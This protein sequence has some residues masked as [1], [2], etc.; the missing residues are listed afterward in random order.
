[1]TKKLVAIP[2]GNL[3]RIAAMK[4][5]ATLSDLKEKT[6]VDRKT[7]RTINTGGQV[8]ETT[9]QAIA[10]K[11]RIPLAHFLGPSTLDEV[12][13]AA[14]P[15]PSS[16]RRRTSFSR[17]Q[18]AATRHRRAAPSC[19]RNRSDYLAPENGPDI[20]IA[21]SDASAIRKEPAWMVSPPPWVG[22]AR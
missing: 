9:L 1:M 19:R 3:L 20:G 12:E 4:S 10:D 11:L 6:G 2:E 22:R 21:R 16:R 7:L 17:D 14:A 8:K 5:I 18:V 13:R 15:R